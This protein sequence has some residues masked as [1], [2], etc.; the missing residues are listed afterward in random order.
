M[1][2]NLRF[3]LGGA[4]IDLS[5]EVVQLEANSRDCL[6]LGVD[7]ALSITFQCTRKLGVAGEMTA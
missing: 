7:Q 1:G 2:N 3:L 6:G 5:H 4:G